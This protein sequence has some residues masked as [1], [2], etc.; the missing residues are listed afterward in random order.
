MISKKIDNGNVLGAWTMENL[1]ARGIA[2]GTRK[3]GDGLTE[4]VVMLLSDKDGAVHL[5]INEDKLKSIGGEI[6]IK[7]YNS[8]Y[9]ACGINGE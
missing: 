4:A 3:Q 9:I 7:E 5:V 1:K 2:I 6:H 8:P